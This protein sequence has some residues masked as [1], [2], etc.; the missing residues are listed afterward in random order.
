MKRKINFVVFV[1][2][3]AVMLFTV[4][5][6]K[7][8][9]QKPTVPAGDVA[10]VSGTV[11]VI[12][13]NITTLK[14]GDLTP[15]SRDWYNFY[16][17]NMADSW[18]LLG[19]KAPSATPATNNPF[20]VTSFADADWSSV[21][22]PANLT[23]GMLLSLT[24][25]PYCYNR[26]VSVTKSSDGTPMYMGIQDF[27]FPVNGFSVQMF[28]CQLADLLSM[29]VT[30][31]QVHGLKYTISGGYDLNT[32]D[33]GATM[34]TSGGTKVGNLPVWPVYQYA[35]SPVHK[36]YSIVCD[37]NAANPLTVAYDGGTPTPITNGQI[38]LF[39]DYGK[40][41]TGLTIDYKIDQEQE[42][43]GVP[44]S[45][46]SY[47][48]FKSGSITPDAGFGIGTGLNVTF[49]TNAVGDAGGN[50]TLLQDVNITAIQ[51][52]EGLN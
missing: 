17:L 42:I 33:I 32:I 27:D 38:S 4:S 47:S 1:A 26:I 46:G 16:K 40:E 13:G 7:E 51:Q 19:A 45:S 2:F 21:T 23:L 28:G 43:A 12:D 15:G 20:L 18:T 35:G 41:I 11:S 37:A 24:Y 5:C 29:N 48:I 34:R 25:A 50:V 36:T 52:T 6:K 22:P 39:D 14:S 49:T 8:E 31:L 44:P 10:F 3:V 9:M 30:G